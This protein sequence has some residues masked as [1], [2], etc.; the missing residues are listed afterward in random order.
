MANAKNIVILTGAG[1]SADSGV[2]TFRDPEGLWAKYSIEEV[3]TPEAFARDPAKVHAF[4]NMRR[5]G[6]KGIEPN[7]AHIALARLEREMGAR[8][9]SVTLISQ[10]VDDLHHRA[11]SRNLLSMHGQLAEAKCQYC[12][13][14]VPRA[15]DLSVELTCEGCGSKGGMRPNVVWF[16]EMPHHLDEIEQALAGAEMFVAIGTSGAV[17]PAAGLVA[18]ARSLH[19]PCVELTLEPSDN[20]RLFTEARYGPAAEIV[21]DWVEEILQ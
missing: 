13:A 17:Y 16:G 15:E 2:A 1:V 14:V 19:I 12:R 3:A 20:A 18:A 4:Y 8:G 11:G 9:G 21:P 7:E 6:L 5:A 10:N